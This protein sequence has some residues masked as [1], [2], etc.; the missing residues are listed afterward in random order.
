ML[1]IEGNILIG[2]NFNLS[3]GEFEYLKFAT[4]MPLSEI[5]TF[6]EFYD[7]SN[8]KYDELKFVSMLMARYAESYENIIKR[9]HQVR[10]IIQYEKKLEE[11]K[12]FSKILEK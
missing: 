8:P 7:N 3:I 6:I 12:N 2:S 5:K 4:K 11:S 9:I 10:R 1:E